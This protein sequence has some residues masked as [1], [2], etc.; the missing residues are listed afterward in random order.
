[1][2]DAPNLPRDGQHSGILAD[3][4]R[5][6]FLDISVGDAS[7]S[8]MRFISFK[9]NH[10][11]SLGHLFRW[12]QLILYFLFNTGLDILTGR[13]SPKRRALRLRRAFERNGGSF[14]KL[15]LHLSMRLDF[16]PWAYCN[17]L[18]RMTDRMKPF[19]VTQ[20]VEAVER[21][22][23]KPLAA[24]FSRFDPD[25]ILSTTVACTYQ[26]IMHSGEK[27]IVKVRRP[28]VGEQ[29]MSD[30]EAFDWLLSIAEFLTIFRPGF[31]KGMR[32]EFRD[33]LLEE[34]DFVQEA[35]R[36]DAF[37]RA[38]A[39]SRKKFFSAPRIHLDLTTEEVVINEFASG[40]WLW[41]LLAAIEQGN[42]AVLARAQEMN[43]DPQTVAKRLLW[44]NY[45]GWGEN[46]FF[47]ADPNPDNI[48][49]GQDSTLYYIDFTSTGTLSRTKRHAMRQNL[50]YAV[51]R[52]PQNM[53][54]ATLV[55]LEPL[56]PIDLIELIQELETYNWELVYA[57]EA[58]PHTVAWQER[59][60][61]VQWEG[62]VELVRKYGIVVDIQVLRVIRATLLS[63]SLAA[64][65]H[66]EVDFLREYRK[67]DRYRAEQARRRVTDSILDRMDGKGTEQTVIRLDRVAH[68]MEGL[69]F[70]T[71]HMLSLPSVNFSALM[72]KWSFAVYTLLRFIGQTLVITLLF[73]LF[74]G[75]QSYLDGQSSVEA[76]AILQK[77][78]FNP[79]YQITVLIMVFVSG[80]TV[81]FRLDDKEI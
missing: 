48:I 41:E 9:I 33:L 20:A 59:T 47:H 11:R 40:I 76:Y 35:R 5:R 43:I 7:L 70:R 71:S 31:T 45:W 8:Q 56:P 30:I 63:E 28:G 39:Q 10:L 68:A 29:F 58:A 22:T 37:R 75:S 18:S 3:L 38:A 1:M 4:P 34:L 74:F 64:R 52:D 27:V 61:A 54:R 65:L 14:I 24:T 46:L 17:E 81:L 2:R 36:Q 57:M 51:E 50:H 55:L 67:F 62:M 44:V 49:I 72:S 23:G 12:F 66:R 80:R 26:A 42:E 16:M 19:P 15:G 25:P 77:V 73:A 21:S 60:S 78:V 79:L 6:R 69:L 13:D 32:G 53:A